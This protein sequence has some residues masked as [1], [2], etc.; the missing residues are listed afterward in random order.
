MHLRHEMARE[1][2]HSL[3]VERPKTDLVALSRTELDHK[4]CTE[5]ALKLLASN[6]LRGKLFSR[7]GVALCQICQGTNSNTVPQPSGQL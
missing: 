6:A 1:A 2:P 3:G 7:G 5:L 4:S